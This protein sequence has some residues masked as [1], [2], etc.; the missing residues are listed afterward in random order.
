MQTPP[1]KIDAPP[2]GYAIVFNRY[3]R[4][5]SGLRFL[6]FAFLFLVVSAAAFKIYVTAIRLAPPLR[7]LARG[8]AGFVTPSLINLCAATLIGWACLRV[9]EGL[10]PRAL[11][12][13]FHRRWPRDLAVGVLVGALSLGVALL[14]GVL[15]GGTRF[16]PSGE[17]VGAMADTLV[18]SALIFLLGAAGEEAMFRGYPLQTMLRSWPAWLALVPTSLVFAVIH[19]DNPNVVRGF[20]FLNT[21]LAGVWMAVAYL[22]TRS[23]WF[24]LGVHF[25]WNWVM[26]ALLG[27]PVSGITQ[28]TPAPLLRAADTGPTWLTGGHY[29]VEGGA[30]CTVALLLSTLFIWRTR[31]VSAD[32]EMLRLTAH[33]N[34]S[35]GAGVEGNKD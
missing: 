6:L 18:V 2:P 11:G 29:G 5:R 26:G 20:T 27:V 32:P 33:E 34:P 35:A 25:G 22:R 21:V 9:L 17:P 16:F 12:W 23:L 4:L 7:E 8:R 13:A 15:A 24:P 31:L 3:G 28:L 14:P 10:P 30:A 1:P 19:L